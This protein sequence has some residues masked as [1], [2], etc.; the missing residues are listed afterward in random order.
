MVVSV[1]WGRANA[2]GILDPDSGAQIISQDFVTKNNIKMKRLPRAVPLCYGDGKED[3]AEFITVPQNITIQ[4]FT[5]KDRFIVAP[6][7]ARGV[8]FVLGLPFMVNWGADLITSEGV[9]LFL[10]FKNSTRWWFANV[11]DEEEEK[12]DAKCAV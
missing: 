8:D 7:S 3:I 1:K 9:V 6:S 12:D 4:G 11:D 10:R 2:R 5:L